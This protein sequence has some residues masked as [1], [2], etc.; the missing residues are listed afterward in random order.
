MIAIPAVDIR[1]GACVQLVG[2]SYEHEAVRLADPVAVACQWRDL[3]FQQ[4][5]VIDL[6]A[7]TRRGSNGPIIANIL[8][9]CRGL[10]IQVGGGVRAADEIAGLLTSGATRVIVGSQAIEDGAW[11]AD[12]ATRYPNRLIVAADVR[13]RRV[14]IRGWAVA[15][16]LDIVDALKTLEGLPL[17][18]VLVTAVHREGRLAGP[19]LSLM[20]LVVEHAPA[21]VYAAGGIASLDDLRALSSRGVHAAVIGMALYTGALPP[22]AVVAE[23]GQ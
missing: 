9:T 6:D 10:A 18:G 16:G 19:D 7:A 2:G 5:H 17:A 1:S 22:A 4:L 20:D 8:D 21:D 12:M 23:F 11:I 14:V 13:E 15:V 3:G